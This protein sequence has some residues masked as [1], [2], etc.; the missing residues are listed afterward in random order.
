MDFPAFLIAMIICVV[1]GS[2][3]LLV[4]VR[5]NVKELGWNPGRTSRR[6]VPWFLASMAVIVVGLTTP[7]WVV[8]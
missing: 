4:S 6:A 2:A 8:W 3:L 7:F 1:I 5:L